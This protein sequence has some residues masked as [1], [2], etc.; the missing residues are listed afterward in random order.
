MNWFVFWIAVYTVLLVVFTIKYVKKKDYDGYLINNRNTKLLPL[1]FTTLAT[2][3]GGGTSM[4]LIAMGYASGFAAVGIGVAY[5]IGFIILYFFAAKIRRI[6]AEQNIYSFAEFLN[7]A[8]LKNHK[9]SQFPKV[10]SGLVSGINI[11]IFFFL[12]AA[13]FVG[14]ATLLHYAF[15][16]G[17]VL[18]AAISFLVVIVYTAFAGLSGVIITDSIQFVVILLMIA[19]IFIPGIWADTNGFETLKQ[20]PASFL[21]GTHEGLVFLIALPILLSP[22]VLTRMDIW[23]RTLAANSEKTAKRNSLL[24][25]FSMLPFYVIFPL[26]GMALRVNFGAD[27]D[28]DNATHMFLENNTNAIFLGFAVVGLLAALMSSADS[29]LNI[30]AMTAVRDFKSYK[31]ANEPAE[32]VFKKVRIAVVVFGA[33]ALGMALYLSDIVELFIAGITLNIIFTPVALLALLKKDV[34]KYKFAAFASLL[35]GTIVI[36]SLFAF[37]FIS[38]DSSILKIAFVPATIVATIAMFIGIGI[39]NK[40]LK[41]EQI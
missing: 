15:D 6:G 22:S 16:V 39:K 20:L 27:I 21:N 1:L 10:F 23:Q 12:T 13:Q 17:F 25:A 5:V 38:G 8:F 9:L 7:K 14:M 40:K 3:V 33:A 30:V 41:S 28:P 2:F 11:V 35:S 32:K 26:V 31:Q 18:A 36:A 19:A 4:G 37:G 29:F 34:Y 24:S